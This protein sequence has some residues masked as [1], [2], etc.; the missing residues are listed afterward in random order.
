MI[1]PIKKA[2]GVCEGSVKDKEN[3]ALCGKTC[4][5]AHTAVAPQS[6][7]SCR[8]FGSKTSK[9]SIHCTVLKVSGRKKA[10]RILFQKRKT[11]TKLGE[12][13]KTPFFCPLVPRGRQRIKKKYIYINESEVVPE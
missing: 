4:N 7:C 11:K 12:L 6:L 3:A 8:C 13:C 5:K 1:Y 10:E 9:F 2:Y